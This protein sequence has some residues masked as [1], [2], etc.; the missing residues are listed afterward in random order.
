VKLRRFRPAIGRGYA[1]EYVF[2][3]RLRI[4]DDDIEIAILVEYARVHQL[5]L[6]LF[7]AATP[8]FFGKPH[9][10]ELGL[11]VFIEKLHVAVRRCRIEIEVILFDILAVIA[12]GTGEPEQALFQYRIAPVPQC[13]RKADMLMV[14]GDSGYAVF[15]PAISFRLSMCMRQII[16]GSP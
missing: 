10:W 12:L 15:A 8:V 11:R 1:D 4:F 14:V 6:R 5:E 3:S 13:E 2:W 7:P 9:V 16:P